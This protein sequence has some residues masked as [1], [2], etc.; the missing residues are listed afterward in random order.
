M[1]LAHSSDVPIM[2]SIANEFELVKR[3]SVSAEYVSF[4]KPTTD[5][6]ILNVTCVT[7]I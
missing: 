6:Y 3:H 4:E 2:T 5:V 7:F 1:Q